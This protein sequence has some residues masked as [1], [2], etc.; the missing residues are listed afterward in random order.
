MIPRALKF[1]DGALFLLDQRLLPSQVVWNRYTDADSIA[2]A[3][4]T[5]VV[6]GAPAIGVAAAYGVALAAKD[7]S[8]EHVSDSA[9]RLQEARPTAVNLRWAVKRMLDSAG[10]AGHGDSLYDRLV[11]EAISIHEE[12]AQMC[13][14]IGRHGLELLGESP[15]IL[16]YCNAGALA[17]GGI[18]TAL[19][20]VYLAFEAGLKS[21]VYV[22][23]TRPVM[24]GARLTAWELSEAGI[25]VTL[26][27]DAAAAFL[28]ARH[29]VQSVWVGA[30][31]IAA[32]GDVANKIGTYALACAA[33][34]HGVPFYVAAPKS[35]FDALTPSG[36]QIQIEFRPP[37][38]LTSRFVEPVTP[39]AINYWTPA[40]DVT[41]ADLVSAY[42]TDSGIKLGG[43]GQKP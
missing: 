8:A 41:P 43:R 21:K 24:Q 14:A 19:A 30:D 37:E 13:R 22:C 4:R 38:E 23:E 15:N 40:F 11:R 31:R 5:L 18:G 3:I 1:E 6:R 10:S 20:P 36:D 27:V 17:T 25:D 12:D 16:T 42:V 29:E 32:N 2:D 28:L 34:R 26:L 9:A 35:T 7:G 39:T 33:A